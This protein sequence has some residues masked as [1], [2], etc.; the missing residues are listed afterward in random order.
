MGDKLSVITYALSK[1]YTKDTADALGAVKGAPCTIKSITE[2]E[3][4]HRITFEW[5]GDSGV[6]QTNTMDVMDGVDGQDGSKGDTGLGIKAVSVNSSNHLVVTYDDD[7]TEDAGEIKDV[8]TSFDKIT[9]V[10]LSNLTDGQILKYNATSGKW[11]NASAG[12]V[13]TNLV[14]LNDVDVESLTDGQIIVWDATNSKWVNADNEG[15][16][17]ALSDLTDTTITTPSDGEVLVYDGTAGKWVNDEI[18]TAASLSELTDTTITTPADGE[19]L[20]YDGTAGKWVNDEIET[21]TS[22]SELTDTTISS[23]SDGQVLAY[24]ATSG[25]WVNEDNEATVTIDPVPTSGSVNAVSSGGVYDALSSKVDKNGTD[26]LMTAAEGTKLA[27]IATG[28]E[29]NV[30]SDWN[31]TDTTADDFIK[32]KP[33]IPDTSTFVQKSQTAGLLKNDGTVDTNTYATTSQI[34]S[35]TGKADKVVGAT[36]GNFAGLDSTGNLIDSGK[37]AS[38]FASASDVHSIPSG[39]TSGQVLAKSSGTDYDVSWVN[40]AGGGGTALWTSGTTDAVTNMIPVT[41]SEPPALKTGNVVCLQIM[42]NY[43]AQL[44]M[45]DQSWGLQYIVNGYTTNISDCIFEVY[46]DSSNKVYFNDDL[47]KGDVLVLVVKEYTSGS[48]VF[49]VAAH[50]TEFE[51]TEQT[52]TLSTSTTTTVTFTSYRYTTNSTVEVATSEWGLVPENV[53]LANGSCTVTLP[54]ASSAHSVTVRVYTR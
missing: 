30:Q 9:D 52:A 26:R 41:L 23:P 54:I 21:V 18:E 4:G 16:A 20:V 29:V 3:G 40:A 33:T 2:I 5:T 12:S 17:S 6:K 37:K 13:D 34:P 53:V 42:A 48:K 22:L 45:A 38:D 49:V 28:A 15:G 43:T 19:V 39:G 7:T 36:N 27:G 24:D 8:S 31:Q 46:S 14:D 32:N 47:H 25:K 44:V 51:Y 11:E 35:V 1:K 10:D 50:K